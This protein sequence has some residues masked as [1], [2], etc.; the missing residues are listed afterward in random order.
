MSEHDF[1]HLKA[2]SRPLRQL[3][4]PPI[5][6]ERGRKIL[7]KHGC[8]IKEYPQE[9]II[10]FPEGTTKTEIFLRLTHPRYQIRFPDGFELREIY[11]RFQKISILLCQSEQPE[12]EM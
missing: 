4:V 8:R 5:E 12:L 9:C 11:D 6:D 10:F 7:L 2:P 1:A 3:T